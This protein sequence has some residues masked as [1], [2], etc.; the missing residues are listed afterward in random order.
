MKLLIRDSDNFILDAS[1][2][3]NWQLSDGMSVVEMEGDADS[4]NWPH[5]NGPS[6]CT[7]ID[8]VIE[9]ALPEPE[10]PD[11]E[12][13][14]AIESASTL[15]ELKKALTGRNTGQKARAAAKRNG[16]S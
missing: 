12:L 6:S 15:D 3:G 14:K 4:Y 8:G 2:V 5:S 7:C 10:N 1:N 9:S 13:E 11:E 16:Q